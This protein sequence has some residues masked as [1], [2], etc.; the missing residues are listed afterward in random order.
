MKAMCPSCGGT[1]QERTTDGGDRCLGC[2]GTGFVEVEIAEG[3]LYTLKCKL[4]GFENGGRIVSKEFPLRPPDIG[5]V[6]CHAGK[7]DME[8]VKVS[9]G[10]LAT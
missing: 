8:Y 9:S 6:E 10:D 7:D 5:C 3:E 1:G 2:R 4:C